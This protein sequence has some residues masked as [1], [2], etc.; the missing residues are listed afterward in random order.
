MLTRSAHSLR[1]P[2]AIVPFFIET[3]LTVIWAGCMSL[4][5]YGIL[6]LLG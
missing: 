5:A 3:A 2:V 6:A 4:A 1:Q